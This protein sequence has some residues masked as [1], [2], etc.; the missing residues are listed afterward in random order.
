MDRRPT[1][2]R[3]G[4]RSSSHR[5]SRPM[6]RWQVHSLDYPCVVA[7]NESGPGSESALSSWYRFSTDCYAVCIQIVHRRGRNGRSGRSQTYRHRLHVGWGGRSPVQIRPP[8]PG[9]SPLPERAFGISGRLVKRRRGRLGAACG[10]KWPRR[11]RRLA[12]S[13]PAARPVTPPLPMRKSAMTRRIRSGSISSDTGRG[14][15]FVGPSPRPAGQLLQPPREH[16]LSR[17]A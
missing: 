9:E 11:A 16:T 14:T 5:I 13:N 12:D 4:R 7:R 10:T 2:A 8:R 17:G 1:G 3:L 6:R 15:G